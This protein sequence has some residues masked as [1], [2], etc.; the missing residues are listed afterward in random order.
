MC[1]L[2]ATINLILLSNAFESLKKQLRLSIHDYERKNLVFSL[3]LCHIYYQTC[4]FLKTLWL[5][6]TDW[7]SQTGLATEL[8]GAV[9]SSC[10]AVDFQTWLVF[11]GG[12]RYIREI[13]TPKI[14]LHIMNSNRKKP[15]Q[16]LL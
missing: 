15:R 7:G 10:G 13:G 2:C 3:D 9:E 4:L 6:I 16:G 8:S 1:T 5:S 14:G 12:P 11:T